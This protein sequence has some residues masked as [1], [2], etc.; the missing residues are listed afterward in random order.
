M[1]TTV[2]FLVLTS[3]GTQRH[4]LLRRLMTLE[5]S[6]N[7]GS[8]SIGMHCPSQ[9]RSRNGLLLVQRPFDTYLRIRIPW[10]PRLRMPAV[11]CGFSNSKPVSSA[12]LWT[13][14]VSFVAAT[15]GIDFADG[16]FCPCS[17]AFW[18]AITP[19]QHLQTT[20]ISS[21]KFRR[22]HLNKIIMRREFLF[23]VMNDFT[24]KF[25]VR[26][27]NFPCVVLCCSTTGRRMSI[28]RDLAP[29]DMRC[30]WLTNRKA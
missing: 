28:T 21:M 25:K 14:F 29:L 22:Q 11:W 20:T 16:S 12:E 26:K 1:H 17:R 13:A 6:G 30:A 8:S 24:R 23:T 18:R 15:R 27:Q 4:S 2:T 10:H 19:S 7:Q 5:Y 9:I 3:S